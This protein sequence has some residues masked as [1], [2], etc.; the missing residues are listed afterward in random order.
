MQVGMQNRELV[1]RRLLEPVCERLLRAHVALLGRGHRFLRAADRVLALQLELP[2]LPLVSL[3]GCLARGGWQ[4]VE[5]IEVELVANLLRGLL[6]DL[7]D[8]LLGSRLLIV[9]R[10]VG[11]VDDRFAAL[12]IVREA[13][14]CQPLTAR[15]AVALARR[16]A[17]RAVASSEAHDQHGNDGAERDFHPA[18]LPRTRPAPQG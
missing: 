3:D 5:L 2:D 1:R 10:L 6:V 7:V 12:A 8:V 18:I 9:D 11:F 15:A 13:V 16:A 14:A 4:P 17:R